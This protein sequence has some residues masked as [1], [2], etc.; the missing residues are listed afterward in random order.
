[1]LKR[2][3]RVEFRGSPRILGASRGGPGG[4]G[5]L[6]EKEDLRKRVLAEASGG[7]TP[8]NVVEYAAA[9]VDVVSSAT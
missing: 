1:M 2:L 6:L 5:G 9:G 4:F 3:R 7:I 8:E